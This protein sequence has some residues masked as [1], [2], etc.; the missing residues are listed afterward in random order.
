M[1]FLLFCPLRYPTSSRGHLVRPCFTWHLNGCVVVRSR[2][3]P[4]RELRERHCLIPSRC[5]GHDLI[6][7]VCAVQP[8]T[9][10]QC[11]GFPEGLCALWLLQMPVTLGL[12]WKDLGVTAIASMVD[13]WADGT[14]LGWRIVSQKLPPGL[15]TFWTLLFYVSEWGKFGSECNICLIIL[16]LFIWITHGLFQGVP[17]E[18]KS[19]RMK[20]YCF[21]FSVFWLILLSIYVVLWSCYYSIV[22][23]F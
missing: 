19:L 8:T 22:L 11:S 20:S 18:K 10:L 4:P 7:P 13:E 12:C 15:W 23:I 6:P 17:V 5:T 21:F 9:Y 1:A 2:Q 14:Q 16:S 3:R